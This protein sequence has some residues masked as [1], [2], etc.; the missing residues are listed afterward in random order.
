MRTHRAFTLVE[1]LVVI[2]II[3]V[4]VSML[5]PAVQA[6]RAAARRTQCS[7]NMRQIGLGIHQFA[8][9][10]KGRFPGLWHEADKSESWIFTLAPYM[11]NVD[12]VRL[13]PEDLKRIERRSG[14][15][16]S[17]VMNGYLR[18]PTKA[19][20]LVHPEEAADMISDL[21][22]LPETHATIMM[23]E[24]ADTTAVEFQFD[25]VH[26]PE[27]FSEENPTPEDRLKAIEYEVATERHSHTAANYLY[28]DG[29]VEAIPASQIAEWA[30]EEHNFA[31]PPQ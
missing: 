29:H 15:D 4:L 25:H 1:L 8:D 27:W 24:A 5:L 21:Y 14:A 26:S 12:K 30:E 18:R 20:K 13:C 22:D 6:A 7:N 16:T 17:Y 28:A 11:E 10:H 19:E 9:V 31:R 2:A 3:G 23:F